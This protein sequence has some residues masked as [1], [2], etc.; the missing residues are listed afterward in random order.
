MS[1]SMIKS[2][3]T[4][5]D[6]TDLAQMLRCAG[7]R[8]TRQRIII[9]GLLLD[10]RHRHVSAESLSAEIQ[11][12]GVHMAEGTIYNTLNQFTE[13][14]L[15][16]RVTLH[17]DHSLFDTNTHHHHHFYDVS[18]DQLFDIPREH[19]VLAD[20]PNA[21]DGHDIQ[22]VDVIINIKPR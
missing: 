20:L 17:N 21:P 12:H 9:A 11:S 22:S 5:P 3:T 13:A 6:E 19:V 15:L 2:E 7:L 16:N 10:G 4:K 14:G 8:P 18:S 1:V